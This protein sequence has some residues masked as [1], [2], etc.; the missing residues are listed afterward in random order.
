MLSGTSLMD[1]ILFF[2]SVND[3]FPQEQTIEHLLVLNVHSVSELIVIL[4]KIDLQ[5][6]LKI[7]YIYLTVNLVLKKKRIKNKIFI[8]TYIF[9]INLN[10][11]LKE[12]MKINSCIFR[13][14]NY[15]P[16]FII[17]RVF[18]TKDKGKVIGGTLTQGYLEKGL[19][20]EIKPGISE[21]NIL[22]YKKILTKI[23]DIKDNDVTLNYI[24][25]GGLVGL[26]TEMD[27]NS[28]YNNSFIG[29]FVGI[30]GQMPNSYTKIL[31]KYYV[32]R[33]FEK[34]KKVGSENQ[35][36]NFNAVIVTINSANVT[37]TIKK[38]DKKHILIALKEQTCIL[39]N[40][41]I[42]ISNRIK[43]SWSLMA[44]GN[45]IRGE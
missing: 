19:I 44:W 20:I 11:I 38:M 40:Q 13:G 31:I 5:P 41:K 2:I 1:S 26:M 17:V 6:P 9:D 7:I 18:N 23:I 21:N 45:F 24:V 28:N 33:N 29:R 39:K 8:N 15:H 22:K 16:L 30:P 12:I 36:H 35:E 3:F 4:S 25:P 37:G 27:K 34:P 42:V 10:F 14:I 43:D 32:F